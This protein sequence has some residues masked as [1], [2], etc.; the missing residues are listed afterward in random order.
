MKL[1]L[2]RYE[3]NTAN[4]I[5][6][7]TCGFI[8]QLVALYSTTGGSILEMVEKKWRNCKVVWWYILCVSKVSQC[9]A[10]RVNINIIGFKEHLLKP[11]N[12]E[13]L[14]YII[15]KM[16]CQP[17]NLIHQCFCLLVKTNIL[18]SQGQMALNGLNSFPLPFF[19]FCH[20]ISS[21]LLF[22]VIFIREKEYWFT[23]CSK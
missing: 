13:T 17:V 8:P 15:V 9:I 7:K 3:A 14:K 18:A 2:L 19:P 20:Q 1:I 16:L 6:F 22:H 11:W 5:I 10:F 23:E 12:L 4:G 21:V